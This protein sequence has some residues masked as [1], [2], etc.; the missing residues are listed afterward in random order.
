MSFS[1]N[2]KDDLVK[3]KLQ[4]AE[5][6]AALLCALTHTAGAITLGR[7]GLAIEY[8]S[9]NDNVAKLAESLAKEIYGLSATVAAREVEG[10]KRR[11]VV[12]RVGGENCRRLLVESGCLPKDDDEDFI[13]GN[14]PQNMINTDGKVRCFMRGAFLGAGS[15]SDPE[16]GYHLELVLRQQGF[17]QNLAEKA[18]VYGISGKVTARKS[19]FIYYLKEGEGVSD[20]LSLIGAMQATMEFERIRVLRFM[21]NDLNRRTNFEDANMQK[22]AMS[23][24]R[25]R[26]DIQTL[27]DGGE[28]DK[29]PV[30]LK[31]TAEARLNNPEATLTEL[32]A[33]LGV[34]K[35]CLNHRLNKLSALAEDIRLHG[36]D[37][38]GED[39]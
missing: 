13:P 29:L 6:K 16:K 14:I 32:A 12:V 25:H 22:A 3:L 9:E 19:N 1:S 18:A 39:I 31:Q 38:R 37:E 17:A 35:S 15:I 7:G 8:V 23:S 10:L 33:E 4:S 34:G 21:S 28:F 30:K 24:A 26:L 36:A 2:V 27:I 20:F 5:E 11:S